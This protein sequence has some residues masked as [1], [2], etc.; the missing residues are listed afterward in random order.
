MHLSPGA[1]DFELLTRDPQKFREVYSAKQ[2]PCV[3]SSELP[4]W[5]FS[6]VPGATTLGTRAVPQ[7]LTLFSENPQCP[8]VQPF[9]VATCARSNH[10]W[11]PEL[12]QSA[13]TLS[14][15]HCVQLK[16]MD[17]LT[18]KKGFFFQDL[19]G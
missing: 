10:P 11:D 15:I 18:D 19:P 13:H 5:T 17:L 6:P 12:S 14:R 8:R 1:L 7:V 4:Q 3:E 2:V 9:R 16:V